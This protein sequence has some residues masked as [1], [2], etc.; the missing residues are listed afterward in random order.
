MGQPHP[1]VTRFANGPELIADLAAAC[2]DVYNQA[3]YEVDGV[4]FSLIPIGG[5]SW[6]VIEG[7]EDL[8]DWADGLLFCK[9][10][11]PIAS[12]K[13]KVHRGFAAQASRILS[14]PAVRKARAFAGHSLGGAIAQL[15]SAWHNKPSVSFGSPRV[16][17]PAFAEY[18]DW[19]HLRVEGRGDRITHFP[20]SWLDYHHG[21]YVLRIG[22][23]LPWWKFWAPLHDHSI[24]DYCWE[25][26]QLV[27][28]TTDRIVAD[29]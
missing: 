12:T 1:L 23:R 2:R 27:D 17:G 8:E 21:G 15:L 20:S 13:A 18:M 24:A 22:E 9:T 26:N 6:V 11:W 10:K 29:G 14:H 28:V 16:G 7:S 4:R 3:Q 25:L 5:L 19:W